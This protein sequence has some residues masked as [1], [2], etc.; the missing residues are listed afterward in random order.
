MSDTKRFCYHADE[1]FFDGDRG[2]YLLVKITENEPGYDILSADQ[3]LDHVREVARVHNDRLGLTKDD[4]LDIRSSS[5]AASRSR[6]EVAREDADG[7]PYLAYYRNDLTLGFVWSGDQERP[8]QVTREMGEPVIDT[9]HLA[10]ASGKP[11]DV[12]ARFQ[13]ACDLWAAKNR[14]ES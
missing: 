6:R 8:V 3:Q 7:Y 9:F 14:D 5:M 1:S 10:I 11:A 13:N 2:G 12:L 4:V